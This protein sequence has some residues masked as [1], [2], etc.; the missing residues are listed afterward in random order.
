MS[1]PRRL[2]LCLLAAV[3]VALLGVPRAAAAPEPTPA[4]LTGVTIGA[5][6]SVSG[7][8]TVRAGATSGGVDPRT[9]SVSVGGSKFPV[10][11]VPIAQARRATM[12]VVDTSGSMGA[13]GMA[14][15]RDAVNAFLA[16]VPADVEVGLIAFSSQPSV[17]APLSRDRGLVA[18]GVAGLTSNGETSIFDAVNLGVQ[19]LGADGDRSILLLSDG[20]D[21][22]SVA[23]KP[24]AIQALAGSGVRAHVIAFKTG[25]SD[26]AVLGELAAAGQGPVTAAEDTAAVSTAF[27][28]AAKALESQV[29]WVVQPSES[30]FGAQDVVLSG[31]AGGQAFS[32]GVKVDLGAA[33][34]R[35]GVAETT[36]PRAVP[37]APPVPVV[38]PAAVALGLPLPLLVGVLAVFIGLVGGAAVLTAPLFRSKRSVRV[39]AIERYL[40]PTAAPVSRTVTPS[41]LSQGI[42]SFGEK[43]MQGRDSTSKTM[44]LLQRADLP[45]RAGEW[46]VLR[47]IS[48]IVAV[49][50]G[51]VAFS[52]SG[53]GTFGVVLGLILGLFGPP[54]VL[55]FL[56]KRR[57]TKFENQLPDVLMLL[58]S[59]L[60][61]GFSL[62]QA[63]DAVARDS[64]EPAAKEF[65]RAMAESR[66]GSDVEDALERMALRMDSG[67]MK[68]TAMAIGIQRQVGGNLAETL[69]TTVGTLRDRQSI[70]RQ[71][72]ALSA[73][74]KLSAYILVALPIGIFMF[75]LTTNH[76]Y[77]ALLW[78]N[79]LGWSMIVSGLVSLVIGIFWMR[80]VVEVKV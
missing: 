76:D 35:L 13:A 62:L 68:W 80:K 48:L 16:A 14:T 33:P 44:A 59:S 52:G 34:R 19:Q 69:R 45:W 64:A 46:W 73:E 43:V 50:G 77:I 71:V 63:L 17:V 20:T 10:R 39:A 56:A 3:A 57:S 27:Q 42:V 49:A 4:Q 47:I 75:S 18:R 60:S 58:S 70:Q 22:R 30:V 78:S 72:R 61:T 12:I 9:L 74:G 5:D 11:T 29:R 37:V 8:L 53:M 23:T 51:L 31:T 55:K 67:S 24:Q 25:S 15:V 6:R 41:A 79:L 65:G 66:I 36:A 26:T 1:Q 38:A 2:T 7:V 28:S 21:N 32:A 54:F 40:S